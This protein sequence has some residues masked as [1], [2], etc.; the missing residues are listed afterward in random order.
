[1]SV[2]DCQI[3]HDKIS[4][5]QKSD[6]GSTSKTYEG[7]EPELKALDP[8]THFSVAGR[9]KP[10]SVKGFQTSSCAANHDFAAS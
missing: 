10:Y 3:V 7:G 9:F 8:A 5:K 2:G 1:M 6:H 4:F